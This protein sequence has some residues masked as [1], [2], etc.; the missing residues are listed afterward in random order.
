MH[1]SAT[2]LLLSFLRFRMLKSCKLLQLFST[3]ST[4]ST[5]F[6]ITRSSPFSILIT[7]RRQICIIRSTEAT[8]HK[9][10]CGCRRLTS[11]SPNLPS[12]EKSLANPGTPQLTP[13][14]YN[15]A[16]T[17]SN[18]QQ[19]HRRHDG[20]RNGMRDAQCDG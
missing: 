11:L 12:R 20:L 14:L 9:Y 18:H 4:F 7:I 17:P 5:K 10:P 15:T 1:L 6:I 13:Q 2:I 16:P 8:V 3:F 19:R